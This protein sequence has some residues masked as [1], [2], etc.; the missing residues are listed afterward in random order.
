MWF[1]IMADP[2][3]PIQCKYLI[4]HSIFLFSIIFQLNPKYLWDV[5]HV[6]VVVKLF[7]CTPQ[8]L[9]IDLRRN[10]LTWI[11]DCLIRLS[12]GRVLEN[13]FNFV[14]NSFFFFLAIWFVLNAFSSIYEPLSLDLRHCYSWCCR[15]MLVNAYE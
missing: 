10:Y 9:T 13:G 8:I 12:Y 4:R 11:C 6:T 5:M 1:S 14:Y 15:V 2:Y 7:L 3:T